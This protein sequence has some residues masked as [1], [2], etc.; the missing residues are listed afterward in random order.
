[1]EPAE[2][3]EFRAI[4]AG[5]RPTVIVTSTALSYERRYPNWLTWIIVI[6]S[7]GLAALAWPK[8]LFGTKQVNIPA[9]R[10]SAV[11]VRSGP[12]WA[13]LTVESATET[14]AFRTDIATATQARDTLMSA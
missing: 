5:V 2:R 14:V 7:A 3:L 11:H 1:M 10:I 8:I 6:M 12:S 9:S 13:T 4:R